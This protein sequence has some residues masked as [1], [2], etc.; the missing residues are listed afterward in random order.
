MPYV[1]H[2]MFQMPTRKTLKKEIYKKDQ[3]TTCKNKE[4][5]AKAPYVCL[6][7]DI[8]SSRQMRGFI[9]I[10]CHFLTQVGHYIVANL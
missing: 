10:T 5:L 3:I 1:L 9:G 2:V 6:T 8:W 4:L 7:V